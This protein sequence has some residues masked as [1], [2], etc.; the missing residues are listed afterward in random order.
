DGDFGRPPKLVFRALVVDRAKEFARID[1]G[2][3]K[4]RPKSR[5]VSEIHRIP[6]RRRKDRRVIAVEDPEL[7]AG[8]RATHKPQ[9]IAEEREWIAL[10]GDPVALCPALEIA[11]HV[12]ALR[13]DRHRRGISR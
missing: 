7:L 2:T 8:H 11:A 12:P 13:G 4:D 10:E 1:A 3:T 5:L 9:R 6:P